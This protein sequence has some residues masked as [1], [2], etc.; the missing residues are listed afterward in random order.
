MLDSDAAAWRAHPQHRD[1]FDKLRFSLRMGYRCGPC[2]VAPDLSGWYVV[3]PVYNLEG[4]GAGARLEHIG[5]GDDRRVEPGYFWCERF[6]GRQLS[7]TYRWDGG[8]VP[9]SS[10]EGELAEGS[11]TR[12]VRWTRSDEA[13][14]APAVCAELA[15]VG[16]VNVEFVGGNPIEV[17]LRVSPDPDW[18]DEVVPV[19]ADEGE[20]EG[21]VRA[22]DDAGGF[23]GVPRLGFVVR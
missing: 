2:G 14:A 17:H 13:P 21:M 4:M 9:V 10:W 3:R 15:D 18:G 19:W 16:W 12:F 1:W 22:Y 20:P 7:V 6:T 11:L 23:I 8:W 5:A